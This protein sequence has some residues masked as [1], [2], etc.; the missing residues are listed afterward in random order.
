MYTLHSLLALLVHHQVHVHIRYG[1]TDVL[2]K[3]AATKC[4]LKEVFTGPSWD[5]RNTWV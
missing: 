2:G 4:D 1:H 5:I 3:F